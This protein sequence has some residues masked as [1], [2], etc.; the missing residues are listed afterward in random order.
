MTTLE[1]HLA[2]LQQQLQ[3]LAA[4][5]SMLVELSTSNQHAVGTMN[6][7]KALNP[8]A[9]KGATSPKN[10]EVGLNRYRQLQ[11]SEPPGQSENPAERYLRRRS[12]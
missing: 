10:R 2:A 7:S 1:K 9:E 5:V 12:V 4:D 3:Q 11:A 8:P 6:V